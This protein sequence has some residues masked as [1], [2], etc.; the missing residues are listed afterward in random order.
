MCPSAPRVCSEPGGQQPVLSLSLDRIHLRYHHKGNFIPLFII[1]ML[2]CVYNV[3]DDVIK[4]KHFPRYWPFVRGIHRSLVNSPH[5]GQ[6][7]RVL[8][9][10]LICAWINGW[11]NN[12][13]AG[14]LTRH[15]VHYDITVMVQLIRKQPNWFGKTKT[16]LKCLAS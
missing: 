6:W 2:A 12:R 11:M 3:H 1:I 8:M 4:W 7:H 13:E 16:P 10:S 15:R 14:Y 5:K 9:L